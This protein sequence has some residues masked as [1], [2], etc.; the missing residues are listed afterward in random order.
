MKIILIGKEV[1]FAAVA[2]VI[3]SCNKENISPQSL[4]FNSIQV[5]PVSD[6]PKAIE[7]AW[8]KLS[9][10]TIT[11][12]T[13]F[14]LSDDG[15]WG[16]RTAKIEITQEGTNIVKPLPF[17]PYNKVAQDTTAIFYTVNPIYDDLGDKYG[18]VIVYGRQNRGIDFTKKVRV[19]R[20]V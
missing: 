1:F 2:L 19:K 6:T 9:D 10:S 7:Y 13:Q 4:P 18:P 20:I 8:D 11:I 15:N 17:I 16:S 12:Y 3:V 5:L 14:V